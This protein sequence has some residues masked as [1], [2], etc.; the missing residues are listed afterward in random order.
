[1]FFDISLNKFNVG[2]WV[3]AHYGGAHFGHFHNMYVMYIFAQRA[4]FILGFTFGV[5]V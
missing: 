5:W 4:V 2:S 1:M 3:K